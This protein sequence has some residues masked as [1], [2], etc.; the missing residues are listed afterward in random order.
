MILTVQFTNRNA[1]EVN[2]CELNSQIYRLPEQSRQRQ[3]RRQDAAPQRRRSPSAYIYL[4]EEIRPCI[5][6]ILD[7]IC[8]ALPYVPIAKIGTKK[9]SQE[10][11]TVVGE[12]K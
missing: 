7:M 10:T 8:Q 1:Q 4:F 9:C 2:G 12:K 11:N 3:Q 5:S 6:A